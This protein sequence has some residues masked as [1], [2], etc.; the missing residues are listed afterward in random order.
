MLNI[1]SD[2]SGDSLRGSL[3]MTK[4]SPL[5]IAICCTL[6]VVGF[7]FGL[8]ELEHLVLGGLGGLDL[9][10]TVPAPETNLAVPFGFGSA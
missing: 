9:W 2:H 3:Y 1:F 4:Y 7:G 6:T 8:E 10:Y 5:E